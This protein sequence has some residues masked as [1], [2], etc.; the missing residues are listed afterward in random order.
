[1]GLC[2]WTA[3]HLN[4]PENKKTTQQYW[5]KLGW[6]VLGLLAPEIVCGYRNM[7][8]SLIAQ[9]LTPFRLHSPRSSNGVVRAYLAIE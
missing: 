5:R 9:L 6:L 2:V 8:A 1:M 4:L 7:V 3:I